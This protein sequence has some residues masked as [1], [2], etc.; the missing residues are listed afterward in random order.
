[1]DIFSSS[2]AVS[3]CVMLLSISTINN[4]LRSDQGLDGGVLK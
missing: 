3:I 2:S 1:M 4:M